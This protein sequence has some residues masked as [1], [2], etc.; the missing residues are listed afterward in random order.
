MRWGRSSSFWQ[1]TD[2][3]RVIQSWAK[4]NWIFPIYPKPDIPSARC[5]VYSL[6]IYTSLCT[7]QPVY[8]LCSTDVRS[9][10]NTYVDTH[11]HNSMYVT[12]V[13]GQI[14]VI[15]S[16][17]CWVYVH[18]LCWLFARERQSGRVFHLEMSCQNKCTSTYT[19]S[20][21]SELVV[22]CVKRMRMRLE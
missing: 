17:V 9:R 22:W 2:T 19:K 7:I 16:S 4:C 10:P 1:S 11:H 14:N 5:C 15:W 20:P 12:L 13:Y 6:R 8:M 21:S 18:R 3:F